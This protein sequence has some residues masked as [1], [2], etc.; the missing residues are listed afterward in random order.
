[1]SDDTQQLLQ[2]ILRQLQITREIPSTALALRQAAV[3]DGVDHIRGDSRFAHMQVHRSNRGALDAALQAVT[4]NGA[5]AEFGVYRGESLSTIAAHFESQS[6]HG[7]DSFVGLPKAW[8]G[9][10]SGE[11]AFDVGGQPPELDASNVE[12]HVGWFND[13]VPPF[14]ARNDDPFAFCH[15]DA[16]LYVSTKVVFQELAHWFV[17]GTIVVFD[18][19]FGYHGWQHHEHRAFMELLADRDLDFHALALGHMSLAVMLRAS[20]DVTEV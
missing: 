10:A 16:D 15:M 4:L 11:G 8:G 19:Y 18:E 20:G 17:P 12:F 7:F 2:R 13:T 5:V 3:Q 1:M 14:A 9:T 6:V